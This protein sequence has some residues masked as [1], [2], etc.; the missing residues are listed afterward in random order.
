MNQ[1]R[2]MLD[3]LDLEIDLG[4]IA[5]LLAHVAD[6]VSDVLHSDAAWDLAD[7]VLDATDGLDLSRKPRSGS[8]IK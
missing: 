5:D 4:P 6:A 8:Y 1:E 2:S 7:G 3:D